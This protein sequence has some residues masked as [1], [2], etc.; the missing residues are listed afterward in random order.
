MAA[1]IEANSPFSRQDTFRLSPDDVIRGKNSRMIPAV[2]YA[3]QVLARALS[4]LKEGQLQPARGHKDE[5][6]HVV[7]DAGFT[8]LDAITLIRQGFSAVDPED[9]ETRFFQDTEARLWIALDGEVKSEEQAFVKSAIENAQRN[10]VTDV[11]EALAQERL[12]E[13][14][15]WTNAK[16]AR[17]YGY[18][19]ANRVSFLAQLLTLPQEIIDRVHNGDLA[20]HAALALL[21]IPEG[22]RSDAI[23]LAATVPVTGAELA[24]KA[25]EAQA[26]E[27]PEEQTDEKHDSPKVG[28]TLKNLK[29]F[30]DEVCDETTVASPIVKTL[31]ARLKEWLEGKRQDKSLW[32]TL[33]EIK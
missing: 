32:L 5:G 23:A 26:E 22:A 18:K 9:G 16:I 27:S 29:S 11:Q 28:R 25:R 31:F 13:E 30:C 20:L 19:N 3:E 24:D 21:K 10:E 17:T 15:G 2:D 33:S 8:R 12:R 7:I 14:F 6:D 4:I 1:K